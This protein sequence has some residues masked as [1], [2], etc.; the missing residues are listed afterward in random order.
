[1][2]KKNLHLGENV[3]YKMHKKEIYILFDKKN[4]TIIQAII[5]YYFCKLNSGY[6]IYSD[7]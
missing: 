3:G 6:C 2:H 1:M 4:F 5:L 7:F